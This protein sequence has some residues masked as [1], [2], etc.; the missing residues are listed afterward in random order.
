MCAHGE[1]IFTD[2]FVLALK[3]PLVE[4]LLGAAIFA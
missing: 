4:G 2:P 3:T 1:L